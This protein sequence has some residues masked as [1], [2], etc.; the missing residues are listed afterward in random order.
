MYCSETVV[1]KDMHSP[2]LSHDHERVQEIKQNSFLG[3]LILAADQHVQV[4]Y[5]NSLL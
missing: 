5:T 2:D 4:V 3:W 1:G